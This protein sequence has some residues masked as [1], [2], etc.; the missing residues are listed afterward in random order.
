MYMENK[1]FKAKF[2]IVIAK[3]KTKIT[4]TKKWILR[5]KDEP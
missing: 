1:T 5:D 2:Y 4:F 3:K